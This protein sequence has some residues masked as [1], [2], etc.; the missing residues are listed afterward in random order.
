MNARRPPERPLAWY[1]AHHSAADRYDAGRP[2]FHHELL[3]AIRALIG[4]RERELALD[5]GCGTGHSTV[6]LPG[7]AHHVIGCDIAPEMLA[8]APK[9][10]AIDWIEAPAE[11][12]PVPDGSVDLITVTMAFHWFDQRR[13]LAESRRVLRDDGWLLLVSN[14]FSG[15]MNGNP[16]FTDWCRDVLYRRYP[17]P[18]RSPS[19]ITDD[20]LRIAGLAHVADE[21]FQIDIPF[22][23]ESL[24]AYFLTQSNFITRI[25]S[26]EET[27]EDVGAWIAEGLAPFFRDGTESFG[28]RGVIRAIRPTPAEHA[29]MH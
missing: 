11:S 20:D 7:L 19:G 15:T 28:F 12:L 9:H 4:D 21:P 1:F 24:T 22:T 25:E 10:D 13:F 17:T 16:A 18:P 14:G 27:I 29:A 2:R 3:P 6:I 8:L 23:R 26:G 5:V